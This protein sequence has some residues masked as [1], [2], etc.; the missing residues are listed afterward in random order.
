MAKLSLH[1]DGDDS[2]AGAGAGDGAGAAD[3]EDEEADGDGEAG[4]KVCVT[5]CRSCVSLFLWLA[6][7]TFS[8]RL[9]FLLKI[10]EYCLRQDFVILRHNLLR[11]IGP[12]LGW[13]APHEQARGA[14]VRADWSSFVSRSCAAN[15]LTYH[16]LCEPT[17]G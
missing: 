4:K 14:T 1:D 5:V 13:L 10:V 9:L 17:T 16:S 12:R 2:A 6:L 8:L 7:L 3:A 11:C 15:H